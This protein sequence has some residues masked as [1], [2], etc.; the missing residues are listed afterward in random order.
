MH[1][2]SRLPA[3]L[4]ARTAS[5]PLTRRILCAQAK[6]PLPPREPQPEIRPFSESTPESKETKFFHETG[7]GRRKISA[8]LAE[9][10]GMI[11][12]GVVGGI[13]GS[14]SAYT[15]LIVYFIAIG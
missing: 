14:F 6:L 12:L 15:T 3:G 1:V 4:F 2:I 11:V 10:G 13:I 8:F 5:V 9:K 7:S